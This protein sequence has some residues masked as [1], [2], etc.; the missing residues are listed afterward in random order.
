MTLLGLPVGSLRVTA[1]H[2]PST[3]SSYWL[4]DLWQQKQQCVRVWRKTTKKT[5]QAQNHCLW[6]ILKKQHIHA[7]LKKE[8][9]VHKNIQGAKT[10]F[11][12]Y[13]WKPLFWFYPYLNKHVRMLIGPMSRMLSFLIW[14]TQKIRKLHVF[15]GTKY[16]P[17]FI[18]YP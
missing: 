5:L 2:F 11:K 7:N 9:K 17:P 8:C 4:Q 15:H 16:F 10:I 3:L 14:K 1:L 18:S 12:I 6:I 13:F